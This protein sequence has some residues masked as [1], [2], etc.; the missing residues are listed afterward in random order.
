[1]D[2]NKEISK[3]QGIDTVVS[4]LAYGDRTIKEVY[5]YLEKKGVSKDIAE[6]V[7]Q[8]L[9]DVDYI[10]DQRYAEIYGNKLQKKG[11]GIS[12]IKNEMLKK[13]ISAEIV[14][15]LIEDEVISKDTERE[16]AFEIADKFAEEYLKDL[17]IGYD[18]SQEDKERIYNE[19][20]R[21]YGKLGRKLEGK[22]YAKD[23]IYS[24]LDR[25]FK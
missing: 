18:L 1:M 14:S 7:V 25:V 20:K 11:N 21:L 4:W 17:E 5:G 2:K 6:E 22:G 10:N 16:N 19:R 24:A 12:K 3:E 8:H 15:R 9:K 23:V 13:G